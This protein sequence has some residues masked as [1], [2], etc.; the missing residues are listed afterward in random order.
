MANPVLKSQ[1]AFG[2]SAT[3]YQQE[4]Y[5]AQYRQQYGQTTTQQ[6][7][8]TYGQTGFNE[9]PYYAQP[10]A[11]TQPQ[12]ATGTRALTYEDVIIKTAGLIAVVFITG[13]LSWQVAN[14]ALI[15]GGLIAGL[16]LGL[17]N[18]FKKS[19]SPALITLYAACQGIALGGISRIFEFAYSG[20]VIQALLATATTVVAVLALH[21]SGKFR[22][23]A[24]FKK[25][26]FTLGLGYFLF[27]VI[28]LILNLFGVT[29]FNGFREGPIG[30]LVGLFAVGLAAAFLLIDFNDIREG[31]EAGVD[32][33]F[34]WTAAFALL[35]TIIWMYIEFLRLLAIFRD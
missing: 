21:V 9:Q 27:I 23:T 13:A 6:Y 35:V 32:A 14:P 20:I 34:A 29:G 10:D 24:K 1:P 26:V 33:K 8:Q 18:S 17:I 4:Q 7:G 12:T 2:D 30:L 16:V 5:A 15:Y 28:N 22:V 3:K 11:V 31:V 19:P 25:W